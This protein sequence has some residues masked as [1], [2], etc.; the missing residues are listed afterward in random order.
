MTIDRS[1]KPD[2]NPIPF[3]PIAEAVGSPQ[4]FNRALHMRYYRSVCPAGNNPDPPELADSIRRY[5]CV[6]VDNRWPIIVLR[7]ELGRLTWSVLAYHPDR[8]SIPAGVNPGRL[9]ERIYAE[10]FASHRE[11][12]RGFVPTHITGANFSIY[13]GFPIRA[14][15]TLAWCLADGLGREMRKR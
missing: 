15:E 9:V 3:A 2:A 14:A 1:G 5:S 6:C 11:I 8:R 7:P 13:Q 12:F 10:T 4:E